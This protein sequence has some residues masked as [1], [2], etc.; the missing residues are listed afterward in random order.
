M[1]RRKWTIC[2]V[3]DGEGRSS[4]Y[5]GAFT[6]DDM[7]QQDPD[8]LEDYVR[9]RYD[10]PCDTCGGDGK[11]TDDMLDRRR[12][13]R[14]DAYVQWQESGCPEGSFSSWYGEG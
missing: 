2:P 9:G 11:V 8:F 1:T 12:D 6:Q 14:A 4:A 13:R 5:L 10:R 7:D 3:C